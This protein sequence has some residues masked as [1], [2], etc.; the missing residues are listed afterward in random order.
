MSTER[1]TP[2]APHPTPG[3]QSPEPARRVRT[4]GSSAPADSPPP[5]TTVPDQVHIPWRIAFAVS[6]ASLKRRLFRSLITIAGVVLAIAFLT[7]MLVTN[8]IT[9]ALVAANIDSLNVLL[10]KAGVDIL[11]AGTTDTRMIL[12]I[13]LSLLTC[14]VGIIN[15]MLMSVTE[16]T[17]EIG[18]MKCLGAL[19]GFIVR[20]YFIEA[21]MQGVLG[22]LA[23]IALGILVSLSV[24]IHNYRGFAL[25]LLPGSAIAAS[26]AIALL[27]GA[28]ISVLAAIAPARWAAAKEPI[29]AM[30]VEQ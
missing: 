21:V 15:A 27:I 24:A 11:A 23:G 8:N 29:E 13:T 19:G 26:V 25:D 28:G 9:T 6:W 10:Q 22:T 3:T 17:R 1:P 20:L 16:R 7:Y 5:P 18:T 2:S 4:A 30:R 14:L 12:L